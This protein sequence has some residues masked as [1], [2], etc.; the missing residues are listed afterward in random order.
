MLEL[1][2]YLD[3]SYLFPFLLLFARVVSFFALMPVFNAKFLSVKIRIGIAFYVSIF[4]YS[5]I[6]TSVVVN[7]INFIEL[8]INEIMLGIVASMILHMVFAGVKVIGELIAYATALSMSSQMDPSSGTQQTSISRLLDTIAILVFL[9]TGMY[10]VVLMLLS[11]S[12]STITLGAF[13]LYSYDGI[14]I[15]MGELTRMMLF[16][17]SFA[18]PLFFIGFIM[19]VFFGYATRNTPSFSVFV[20]TFQLKFMFIFGFMIL[21]ISVFIDNFKQYF[22]DTIY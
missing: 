10:E 9:E 12:F 17:F 18:F 11:E 21:G 1:V 14:N 15:A 8:L 4:L 20:V 3:S 16:A 7:E 13:D 22:F 5:N 6:D 19:D 2:K